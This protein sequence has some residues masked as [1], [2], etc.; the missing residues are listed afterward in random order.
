MIKEN[1]NF[2]KGD[3]FTKG[4]IIK[5]LTI[6]IDEIYFTVKE[7]STDKNPVLQKRLNEGIKKD[8]N[9]ENRYV[10]NIDANDTNKLKTKYNYVF[11]IEIISADYKK[12]IIGGYLTLKDWDITSKVNEV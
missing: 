8:P 2:I 4:F 11:D 3:T 6:D 12:T 7:K 5:N 9:I 10:L 1:F